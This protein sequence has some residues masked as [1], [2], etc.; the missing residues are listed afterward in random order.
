MAIPITRQNFFKGEKKK[1]KKRR[2]EGR[3]IS[4]ELQKFGILRKKIHRSIN[5]VYKKRKFLLKSV[6]VLI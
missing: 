6:S 2:K 4:L 1:K 5:Q 3:S